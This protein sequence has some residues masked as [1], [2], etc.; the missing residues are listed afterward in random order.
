M[1]LRDYREKNR[2]LVEEYPEVTASDFYQSIFPFDT[3]E[4]KYDPFRRFS[5][6]IF[7]YRTAEYSEKEQKKVA[8]FHNEVVYSDHFEESL[9]L[10]QKNDLALCSCCSYSGRRKLA[11]N[12]FRCHGFIIDLDGVGLRQ[13]QNFFGW[14][15]QLEKIPRPTY[16]VNS[17]NGVHIYYIFENPVPLYPNV[18]QHLQNL[19]H[20]LT[21]W[22]W[23]KETSTYPIKERQHQGIYQAFRMVGS[24]TKLAHDYKAP[25]RYLVRAFRTGPP[26]TIEYLNRFVSEEFKCPENPDYSSWEW[27]DGEHYSL[28]E[29]QL[30]YPDWYQRRIIDKEPPNQWHCNRALYDWW[31]R[32]IQNLDNVKDGNRYHCISMLYVYAQKCM[33]AKELVDADAMNLLDE[34]N[35]LTMREGNDFTVQDIK[36]AAKFY[37][38]KFARMT[39]KE[40]E[41]RTGIRMPDGAKRNGRKQDL[42]L[43]LARASRDILCE[44]K[45]KTDWRDG[46][47]R[48]KGS[49]QQRIIVQEWREK[50]PD[51]RKVDCIKET[52][53]SK[54]TVYRWWDAKDNEKGVATMVDKDY[55]ER[56]YRQ[57]ILEFKTAKTEEERWEFRKTMARLEQIAMQDHGFDYAD[58]LHKL[59][60][61]IG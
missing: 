41:R 48:P 36:D 53:L 33:L 35:G 44:E 31:Y 25:E 13:L 39:K 8:F 51:G 43:K 60:D 17:G 1:S 29:C 20:G 27:V 54:P 46:N 58:Q 14:V 21:D 49:S 45:G 11:K 42:H 22:V 19:K 28:A 12:A 50:H 3:M 47:G 24:C 26:V 5:N 59:I 4:R 38:S 15:E 10:T 9:A 30:R 40:I 61:D 57:A 52:G 32:T 56:E 6:P 34:Y 55:I 7:T 2:Y 16:V 37:N 23:N 18:T